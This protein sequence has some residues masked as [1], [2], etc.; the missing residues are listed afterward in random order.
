MRCKEGP[1]GEEECKD[2]ERLEIWKGYSALG[3]GVGGRRRE[4]E[5]RHWE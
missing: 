3:L 5:I 1:E 4:V 2:E